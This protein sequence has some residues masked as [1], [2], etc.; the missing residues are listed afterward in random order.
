MK[1]TISA[2]SSCHRPRS[3]SEGSSPLI[4]PL[5]LLLRPRW[6][7]MPPT[8][9][10]YTN[11][12]GGKIRND[13]EW[14]YYCRYLYWE[15]RLKQ[16]KSNES[17]FVSWQWKSQMQG[18]FTWSFYSRD[19]SE[20]SETLSL[21]DICMIVWYEVSYLDISKSKPIGQTNGI[22]QISMVSKKLNH[23]RPHLIAVPFLFTP[24]LEVACFKLF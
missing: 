19:S 20:Q 9:D 11:G 12:S 13:N 5:W 17:R 1:P 7:R 22:K 6:N 8:N 16:W 14:K 24:G 4:H 10:T 2:A 21:T 15:P 23:M 18:L 3:C